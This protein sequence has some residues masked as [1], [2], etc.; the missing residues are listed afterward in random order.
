MKVLLG[1]PTL[2]RGTPE[3]RRAKRPLGRSVEGFQDMLG[4][5]EWLAQAAEDHGIDALGTTEHHLHTEGGEAMPNSL[6]LFANL[7]AKTKRLQFMPMSIVLPVRDPIRTAE[8]IAL[9]D[10]MFPGRIAVSFARGYQ[11]RWMQTLGQAE[12]IGS[13]P[14]D[15][16]A[17][18]RNREIFN[19]FLEVVLKAW[20]EDNF[21]HDGKH[22]QAPYPASGIP[23]W[24]AAEWT[25]EFG[26]DGEIDEAGTIHRVGVIPKPATQPHPPIWVPY[27][28]SYETL[29]QAAQKGFFAMV[30]E[31]R[32]DNFR[33]TC[34][35]YR[36]EAKAA[37]RDLALGEGIA[38]LRK[39]FLGDSF[40]E[41]MEMA[42]RT[43]GYWFNRYFSY[44]GLNEVNRLPSDDPT[45]MVTF[46]S[47]RECAERMF[48]THQMLCGTP[49]EVCRQLEALHSCH[50]DG[51]LEWLAWEF[52]STGNAS[53]DE[54]M[55]QLDMFAN[56]VR[57]R[58][59]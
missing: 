56:D 46:G 29:V 21:N 5:L 10:N 22:Y 39:I 53:R 44:F 9:F 52:W 33:K 30:Y 47:D 13:G 41:A 12:R 54:Q 20:T 51:A 7:A 50:S 23:H 40:E 43:A 2:V 8:D 35:D 38:A 17:N 57:P 28:L 1:P 42:T 14:M 16:E 34:E 4:E 18:E 6:L 15:A 11:T 45:K 48:E 27:T 59:E 32:I 49:D 36:A 24:P 3:E 37:G 58:F 26:G 19:E 31:G 55:R 25:R